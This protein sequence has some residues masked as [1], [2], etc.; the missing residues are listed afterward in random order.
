MPTDSDRIAQLEQQVAALQRI[1]A[2]L[3]PIV[4]AGLWRDGESY[5]HGQLCTFKGSMWHADRDGPGRPGEPGAGW[6]LA[7]KR[8]R[9]GRANA[10]G[11]NGWERQRPYEQARDNHRRA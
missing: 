4:Y 2:A 10:R 6:A 3:R 7:V 11:W 9:D 5:R 8:G 1:V